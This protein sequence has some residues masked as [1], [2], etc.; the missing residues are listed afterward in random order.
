M[1]HQKLMQEVITLTS[2]KFVPA[3]PEIKKVGL[4]ICLVCVCN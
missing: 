4:L 2:E 3:V 1:E